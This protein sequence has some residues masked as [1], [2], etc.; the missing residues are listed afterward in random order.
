MTEGSR[1][2]EI[3]GPHVGP[4][5]IHLRAGGTAPLLRKCRVVLR[6]E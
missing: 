1:D 3:A 4:A 5:P 2:L 6:L